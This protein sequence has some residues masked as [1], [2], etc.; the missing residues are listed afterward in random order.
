VTEGKIEGEGEGT[1]GREGTHEERSPAVDLLRG[2]GSLGIWVAVRKKSATSH[3]QTERER[4]REKGG[5]ESA[6]ERERER[7]EEREQERK[8]ER[9]RALGREEESI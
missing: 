6:R 4:E 8:R 5:R 2:L 7:G 1:I 3:L 9:K